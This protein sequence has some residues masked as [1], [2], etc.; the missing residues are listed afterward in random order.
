MFRNA[1]K[2][3]NPKMGLITLLYILVKKLIASKKVGEAKSV[4]TAFYPVNTQE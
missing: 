4:K 1:L 2:L 3:G